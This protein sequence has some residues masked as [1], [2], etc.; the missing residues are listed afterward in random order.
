MAYSFRWT[1]LNISNTKSKV[2][3][4]FTLLVGIRL[5]WARLF[6]SQIIQMTKTR[7]SIS[8]KNTK[9]LI[10]IQ[11]MV[12]KKIRRYSYVFEDSLVQM[13]NFSSICLGFNR[14]RIVDCLSITIDFNWLSFRYRYSF[15]YLSISI[16]RSCSWRIHR[17]WLFK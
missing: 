4:N 15:Q 11:L 13:M 5:W 10:N 7:N 14:T 8:E 2:E 12:H 6:Y 17:Q 16:L 9:L 1:K 3:L